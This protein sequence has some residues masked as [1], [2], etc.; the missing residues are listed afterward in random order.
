MALRGSDVFDLGVGG[1]VVAARRADAVGHAGAYDATFEGGQMSGT[2]AGVTGATSFGRAEGGMLLA[3]RVGA[4]G[5]SLALRGLGDLADDGTRRGWDG[6]AQARAAVA[7]PLARAY[8]SE[9]GG[10][11]MDPWI[12]RTEPRLEA[13]ILALHEGG[14]LVVPA[15]RGMLVP[16]REGGAWIAAAGWSN[17]IGRLGSRAAAELDAIAGVVG[18]GDSVLPV[19]RGRASA[20]GTWVALR[21]DFARV[22]GLTA[23]SRS[24]QAGGAFLAAARIGSSSG[25]HLAVHA[26]ERDGVDPVVARAAIDPPFESSNG[27]LSATGWTGGA[28]VALPIGSRITTLGGADVDLDAR[29][30]VA[31]VGSLELHDPCNCVV[32]RASAAHRIGREGVDAW[33]SVDLPLP[34]Q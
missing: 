5:A 17:A 27:F 19:L 29:E 6:A 34:K 32:V 16:I 24:A 25:L 23:S 33:V 4:L 22:F 15:G 21:A 30:L 3:T 8:A 1:P 26:A 31:A 7:L 18:D 28:R 12:H 11:N 20:G 10:A 13:A 9:D 14:V 2:A